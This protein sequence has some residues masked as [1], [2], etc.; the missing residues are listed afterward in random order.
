VGYTASQWEEGKKSMCTTGAKKPQLTDV[1]A[2]TEK[3][4]LD[5]KLS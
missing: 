5:M 3:K 2:A 1:T 4:K